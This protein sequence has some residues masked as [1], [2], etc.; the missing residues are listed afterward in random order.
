M[1]VDHLISEATPPLRPGDTVEYALG[2]LME[3]R[4]RHLP[5][6]GE[7]KAILGIL[8]EDVLL[9]AATPDE[10]VRD[11]IV[12]EPVTVGSQDHVFEV[13]RLMME[14]DLTTVPVLKDG[15][16]GGLVRRH[17]LFEWF[18][19]SLSTH[20]PG[21]ILALEIMP[22]DYALSRLVHA[23]EQADVRVLSIGTEQPQSAD[24]AIRVTVKIN[25]REASRARAMLEREGYRIVAAFGE[26][27]DDQD[28]ADRVQAFMRYLEV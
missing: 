15:R 26:E 6:V 24:A 28:L 5:V 9:D 27:E 18:A 11:L 7:E 14:H 3:L 16:Y 22:R 23:I 10:V 20:A 12:G 8:S 21:A 19:R 1:T 25:A 13:A 2:L 4:V 17:D